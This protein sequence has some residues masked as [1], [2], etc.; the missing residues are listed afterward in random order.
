LI[1]GKPIELCSLLVIYLG[2]RF[3]GASVKARCS[4]E[5]ARLLD[6]LLPKSLVL[7]FGR[8]SESN[9]KTNE[10]ARRHRN[11]ETQSSNLLY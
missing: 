3:F 10:R 11:N 6:E 1:S 7:F 5:V 8:E 4:A 9:T 2:K